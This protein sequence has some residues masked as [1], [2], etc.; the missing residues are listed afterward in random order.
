MVPPRRPE[1]RYSPQRLLTAGELSCSSGQGQFQLPVQLSP[2]FSACQ[3]PAPPVIC[4]FSACESVVIHCRV[5]I[6]IATGVSTGIVIPSRTP[7]GEATRS[8]VEGF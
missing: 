7:S 2:Q 5:V 8:A 3:L 4:E 6:E 1:G